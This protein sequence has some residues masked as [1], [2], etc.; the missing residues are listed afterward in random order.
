MIGPEISTAHTVK[1][2]R[3]GKKIPPPPPPPQR[4]SP[5]T[6]S[7]IAELVE[8]LALAA[9]RLPCDLE[10]AEACIEA[11]GILRRLERTNDD[12]RMERGHMA[13][14]R[15]ALQDAVNRAARMT[16]TLAA[17]LGPLATRRKG[18]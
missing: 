17:E 16:A 1:R 13:A 11:A 3:K 7:T 5:Q 6:Y 9:K 2:T 8:N 15:D 4:Q 12:A 10:L 14:K 18:E